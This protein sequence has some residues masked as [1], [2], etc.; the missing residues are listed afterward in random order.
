M[1]KKSSRSRQPRGRSRKLS[2]PSV[3]TDS[4]NV[5][6]SDDIACIVSSLVQ[7]LATD[8]AYEDLSQSIASK[9]VRV[10]LAIMIEPYLSYILS[11][12]KT[13]ESR[14]SVNRCA[15]HGAVSEGDIILFKASGGPVTGIARASW[16]DSLDLNRATWKKIRT[17]YVSELRVSEDFL[18]AKRDASYATFIGVADVR[19]IDPLVVTKRDRR[20][21]VVLAENPFQCSLLA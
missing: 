6:Q 2:R 13:I 17:Q 1:K 8:Q 3:S 21:W 19:A 7:R 10:H 5:C 14:F 11:G 4:P 9:R 20:G 15:P 16:V 12:T 18:E